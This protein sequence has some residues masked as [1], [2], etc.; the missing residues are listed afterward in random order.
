MTIVAS[1]I[2]S[3]SEGAGTLASSY[4]MN[5]NYQFFLL[6]TCCNNL[7]YYTLCVVLTF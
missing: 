3:L 6:V 1:Y 2:F 7:Y 4:F 5:S